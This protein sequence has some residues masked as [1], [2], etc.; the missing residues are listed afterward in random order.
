MPHPK[1]PLLA[2]C[3]PVQLKASRNATARARLHAIARAVPLS[4]RELADVF[5]VEPVTVSNHLAGRKI[6]RARTNWYHRLESVD[7]G[8]G[9]VTLVIRYRPTRKRWAWKLNAKQKAAIF[10]AVMNAPIKSH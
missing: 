1:Q 6:A 3:G 2:G 4:Q 9:Y 8:D 10:R 7:V 5:G